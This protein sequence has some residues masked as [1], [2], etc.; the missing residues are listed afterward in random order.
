MDKLERNKVITKVDKPTSWVNSLVVREKPDGSLRVCLDPRDLNRAIKREHFRIPTANELSRKLAGK[1]VFSIV[2]QKDGFWHIELDEPS[3]FLCTFNS[4]YGRY[5]FLRMPFGLSSAPGVFKKR[6]E[7][8]FGDIPG[9]EIIFDD[10]IIAGTN[11]HDHDEIL[12][13]VLQRAK[14]KGVRFNKNKLK[15]RIPEG[16]YVGNIVS[17]EG[18]KPDPDKVKAITEM[19]NPES[20]Q[21]LQ[22]LLG[23]VNYLAKFI[24][25][26]S[27][28]TSNLRVLLKKDVAW[29]WSHEH[30][31]SLKNLKQLLTSAPVLKY[32][33]VNKPVEIQTDASRNGLGS[34]LLQE[35]HPIAYAS[36]TLTS[37]EQNYAQIEKELLAIVFACN[38]FFQYV[39]GRKTTVQTDH[40]PL[41]AIVNKPLWKASPRLQRML[42]KLQKYTLDVTY[43]PGKE[44]YVVVKSFLE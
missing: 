1:C 3:S 41:E 15:L 33:D 7:E 25:N 29:N 34:C 2:D 36:R 10:I 21:D 24:P 23:M 20:K 11:V 43:V 9:V 32:F 38:K 4:P 28:V 30:D 14:D 13:K 27:E 6:N 12:K 42:L 40:K 5:R 8:I 16:K 35:G 26:M 37:A 17:A 22:R 18:N 39:Y 44:M 31:R 19:P